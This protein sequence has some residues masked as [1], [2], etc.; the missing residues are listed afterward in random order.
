MG[1]EFIGVI[2]DTGADVSSVKK[3]DLVIAPFA[4]SDGTCDYCCE[5][6]QTSCRH[7]GFWNVNGVGGGRLTR[8]GC[9][10]RMAPWWRRRSRRS[11]RSFRPC[12]PQDATPIGDVLGIPHVPG[13]TALS[14]MARTEGVLNVLPIPHA[15]VY[16]LLRALQDD[17]QADDFAPEHYEVDW[18]GRPGPADLSPVGRRQ[19]G[20]QAW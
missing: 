12:S 13:W 11:P 18:A 4:W 17:V 20:L 16:L 19:F 14:S 8:C 6:L 7:G 1:H 15:M 10:S 5:G 2:E 3:G 9:R